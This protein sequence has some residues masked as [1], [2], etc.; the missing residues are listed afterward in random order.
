MVIKD[1]TC[2][3]NDP[4]RALLPWHAK[5][6]HFPA[7]RQGAHEGPSKGNREM[8]ADLHRQIYKDGS[9]K[10]SKNVSLVKQNEVSGFE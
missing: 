9:V 10:S 3:G 2:V 8:C 4:N 7:V 1:A 5:K 6:H